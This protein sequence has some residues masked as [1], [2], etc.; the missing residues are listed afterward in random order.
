MSALLVDRVDQS[1]TEHPEGGVWDRTLGSQCLNINTL[2]Y[3]SAAISV[4]LDVIIL[5]LP[6]PVLIR[7]KMSLKKKLSLIVMFSLGSL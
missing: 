4:G 1:L 2:S 3:S 7:I 6:I 5:I